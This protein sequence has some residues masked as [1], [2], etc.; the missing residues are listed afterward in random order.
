MA[1]VLN[2]PYP[3]GPLLDRL[4]D[5]G[6]D[7]AY[8]FPRPHTEGK[9]DFSFS[10]LKTAVINQAHNLRQQGVE[11]NAKDWAASFRR[12]VVDLLVDKTLSGGAGHGREARGRGRRRGGQFASARGAGAP[13]RE[14]GTSGV[15]PAASACAP[16]TQ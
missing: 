1:R 5:E 14:G 16:T 4:A 15:H 7:H 6:D 8:K 3:G 2:I 11:I 13:G 9:Y 10:G 12:S